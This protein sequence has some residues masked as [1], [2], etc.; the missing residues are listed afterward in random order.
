MEIQ[1][2]IDGKMKTFRQD[3]VNFKTIR[4]CLEWKEH[5][6]ESTQRLGKLLSMS[7]DEET[8]EEKQEEIEEVKAEIN[9]FE[10]LDMTLDLVM[11]FFD[12]HFTLDEFLNGCYFENIGEF[13]ELGWKIYLLAIEQKNESEEKNKKKS[14][15]NRKK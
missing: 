8:D 4:K 7:I 12:G 3:T 5:I 11:A 9:P 10:D 1:V 13:Y 14:Q 6:D 2:K 15:H